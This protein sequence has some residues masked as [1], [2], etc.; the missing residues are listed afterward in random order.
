MWELIRS[1]R[2]ILQHTQWQIVTSGRG[3]RSSGGYM[4]TRK[5]HVDIDPDKVAACAS[6]LGD[7]GLDEESA[8]SVMLKAL[9][10]IGK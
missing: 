2:E 9:G 7:L 3:A 4:L 8:N 5:T 6:V 10:M 1:L